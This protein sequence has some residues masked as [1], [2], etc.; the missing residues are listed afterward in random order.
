MK[1]QI[2]RQSVLL[3]VLLGLATAASAEAPPAGD[4]VL[5]VKSSKPLP[6]AID[7][8]GVVVRSGTGLCWRT[9]YWT[10]ALAADTPVV[11]SPFP[12]GCAC[13][14]DL[15]PQEKCVPPPP[16]PAPPAPPAPT[17]KPAAE[18]VTLA[19]DAL[20]DF[21]KA[22][23]RPEGTAKLD[24]LAENIKGF[25][26]EVVIAVGHADRFGTEAYN[27]KLS[28]RRAESVKTYLVGKGIDPNRV[29]AEGKG[30]T[31]PKT[32]PDECKGKKSKKVI[33][34]LQPDRRVDIEIIGSK[35]AKM[36][37]NCDFGKAGCK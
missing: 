14:K 5:D 27:Q 28:E 21:D 34:C 7:S 18:K 31:Q 37:M 15:M 20:F 4:I 17:V 8:R 11:G 22:T 24:E 25:K 35:E 33:A 13:D 6:Y 1:L 23:L 16:P 12:A 36:E 19:A 32:K 30:K 2:A 10:P 9:G 29:Y 26:L 3:A